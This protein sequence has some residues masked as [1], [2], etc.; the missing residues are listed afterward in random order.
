MEEPHRALPLN[1]RPPPLGGFLAGEAGSGRVPGYKPHKSRQRK[2]CLSF[3]WA[4]PGRLSS[5]EL[6]GARQSYIESKR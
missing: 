4:I 3:G 1:L 2:V 5:L 6:T